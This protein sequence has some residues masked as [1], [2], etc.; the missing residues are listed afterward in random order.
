[1]ITWG[2]LSPE[3][4]LVNDHSYRLLQYS[5]ASCCLSKLP[6]CAYVLVNSRKP[7]AVIILKRCFSI[8]FKI[9]STSE[10]VLDASEL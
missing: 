5:S 6:G 9:P 7:V 10:T 1:M 4:V 3:G 2:I 8:E